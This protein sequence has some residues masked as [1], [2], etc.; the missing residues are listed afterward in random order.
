MSAYYDE[1]KDMICIHELYSDTCEI[2]NEI[3]VFF[4]S[5]RS[6]LRSLINNTT[7]M[8]IETKFIKYMC[9]HKLIFPKEF[10]H[11]NQLNSDN[12]VNDIVQLGFEKDVANK[13]ILGLATIASQFIIPKKFIDS[14]PRTN[15]TIPKQKTVS[16]TRNK[17]FVV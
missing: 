6:F 12:L 9:D 11:V 16:A 4:K 10:L 15:G 1:T 2:D 5:F 8:E 13:L 3:N 14:D 17:K 7:N